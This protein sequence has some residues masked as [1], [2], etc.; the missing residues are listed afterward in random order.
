MVTCKAFDQRIQLDSSTGCDSLFSHN[1]FGS[2]VKC[3]VEAERQKSVAD[4]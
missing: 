1:N 3:V 2:E 4:C